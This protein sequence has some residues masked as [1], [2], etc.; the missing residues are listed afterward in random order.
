VEVDALL[1]RIVGVLEE[2]DVPYLITG[3]IATTFYGEPRFTNDIDIVADLPPERIADFCAALPSDEFY[4]DEERARRAVARKSQFNVI[5]PRSGLKV[6]VVIP[7]RSDFESSRFARRRRERPA[8]D[9]TATFSSPEDAILKKLEF[10]EKG[11][12]DKH[13]RDIIGVLEISGDAID[14][15]YVRT[16]AERLGVREVWD[17]VLRTLGESH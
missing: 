15:D 17:A 12:S 11:G 4:V 6:D 16:W 13:L 7:E 10:F 9:Y 2:L 5:H 8:P 1:R 14:R 3:S